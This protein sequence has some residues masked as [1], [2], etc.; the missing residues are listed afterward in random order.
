V[1]VLNT[2]NLFVHSWDDREE[3]VPRHVTR[4][5]LY[6]R[7]IWDPERKRFVRAYYWH[8]RDWTPDVDIVFKSLRYENGVDPADQ[9]EPDLGKSVQHN[10]GVCHVVWGQNKPSEDVDGE[11]DYEG[12]YENFNE[13]DIILS[14][15]LR[16]AKLNLDPTLVVKADRDLVNRV[17]LRKG[18]DNALITDKD[19]DAK[20]LELAGTSLKAGL[21]VFN[22]Y[23]R[24]ILDACQCV[25]PDPD[26]IASAAVSSVALKMLYKPMLAE[27]EILR[28]MYGQALARGVEHMIVTARRMS[29]HTV[30][31]YD[32]E[33]GE[34]I[35]AQPELDMSPRI[36]AKPVTDEDGR[37][38]GEDEYEFV[39]RHPGEAEDVV[40]KWPQWFP[41]TPADISQT[42]TAVTTAVGVGTS[43]MSQQTGAEIV[44]QAYGLDPAEEH[45]R[46]QK[47]AAEAQA[48]T[49]SMFSD[50]TGDA[51]GRVEHTQQLPGGGQVK[52]FAG[53]PHPRISPGHPG[54]PGAQAPPE[55]PLGGVPAPKPEPDEGE[56]L[57][58][59]LKP[60]K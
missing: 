18:S 36:D 41:P 43:V 17:G 58:A 52:R 31:V 48:N 39:E 2:K 22:E 5:L 10:D 32:E 56:D 49:E 35:E 60:E 59:A 14:I 37:P 45:R 15:V 30:T 27:G 55:G 29:D 57:D 38:T 11:A 26:K 4:A 25:M 51:G 28:G 34:E 1:N 44:A 40:P 9:W 46:V 21:E 20:Y 33:T 7:D 42:T 24:T 16:G 47:Q 13:L 19:G 12:Q 6:P 54:P 23:R 3:L 53:A 50:A 8:R